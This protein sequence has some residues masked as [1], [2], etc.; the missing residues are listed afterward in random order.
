MSRKVN[1]KAALASLKSARF[2]GLARYNDDD[3]DDDNQNAND[4]K[5]NLDHLHFAD[6]D[7]VYESLTEQE[8]REYVERRRE[9]EDFVVDDDGLGYHD[10]G[11]YDIHALGAHDDYQEN[12]G[13]KKRG[14][15]TA[16]LTKDALRKARKNKAL[17][18]AGGNGE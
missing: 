4:P 6:P 11:E 3:D 7:D 8:Y 14:N 12:R 13:G 5:S 9:R 1:R 10:D 16:A 17:Q 2:S 15:G 18:S